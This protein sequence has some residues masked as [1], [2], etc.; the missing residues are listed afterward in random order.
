MH[1]IV[2][3]A[4]GVFVD[5][6]RRFDQR[7]KLRGPRGLHPVPEELECP[8]HGSVFPKPAE[9]L[10][11][12]P[13]GAGLQILAQQA[14]EFCCGPLA[15]IFPPLPPEISGVSKGVVAGGAELPVFLT[16]DFICRLVEVF[17]DM[18]PTAGRHP[19]EAARRVERSESNL[20]K[21]MAAS[22]RA[23][24]TASR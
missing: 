9:V 24:A 6:I 16:T 11:Q 13:R 1:Q 3:D 8:G 14:A 4:F 22:G 10:L 12:R 21:T 5:H 7:G 20:S 18:E 17:D 19:A 2:E 23:C 15:Q